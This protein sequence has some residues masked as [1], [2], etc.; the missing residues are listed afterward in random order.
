MIEEIKTFAL[1]CDHCGANATVHAKS[2]DNIAGWALPKLGD[3]T[4]LNRD[5]CPDCAERLADRAPPGI[6][7]V[8]AMPS[9]EESS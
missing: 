2:L 8:R 1:K 9:P 6:R 3:T 5:L 7:Y 4:Y